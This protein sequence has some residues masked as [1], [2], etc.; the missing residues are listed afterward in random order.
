MAGWCVD[1]TD[2]RQTPLFGNRFWMGAREWRAF[3]SFGGHEA[4]Y[5]PRA[6]LSSSA[7]M[8]LKRAY[9]VAFRRRREH[10]FLPDLTDVCESFRPVSSE[11]RAHWTV[12]T[13][14]N[15]FLT[16]FAPSRGRRGDER[17][18][19]RDGRG[20][21]RLK[22][23]QFGGTGLRDVPLRLV[24]RPPLGEGM[25]WVSCWRLQVMQHSLSAAL[26]WCREFRHL[27]LEVSSLL[28]SGAR[29]VR[30]VHGA[31]CSRSLAP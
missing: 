21:V 31:V 3:R 13:L 6:S 22:L 16:T 1:G 15:S 29:F 10:R 23:L 18:V 8:Q 11:G 28:R 9:A 27:A 2:R 7:G 26:E 4:P 20:A 24:D 12:R 17:P 30:Y 25:L 5:S 14:T 19:A